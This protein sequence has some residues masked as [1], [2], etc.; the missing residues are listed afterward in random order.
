[1]LFG[2]IEHAAWRHTIGKR[3]IDVTAIARAMTEIFLKG[4][5]P[6]LAKAQP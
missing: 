1:M 2:A 3:P 4:L 6:Q 5:V